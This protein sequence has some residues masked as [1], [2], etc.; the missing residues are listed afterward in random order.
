[1]T[2]L[3]IF[4]NI[5]IITKKNYVYAWNICNKLSNSRGFKL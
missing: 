3:L 5:I 4:N 2:K 1:M